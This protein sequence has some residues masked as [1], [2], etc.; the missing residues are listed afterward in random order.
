MACILGML[1]MTILVQYSDVIVGISFAS[2]HTLA[3]PVLWTFVLLSLFSGLLY[4]VGRFRFLNRA[5]MLF[6]MYAMLI[7]APLTTQGFWHRFVA[8]IATNPRSGSFDRLD[9]TNDK[10]WPHGLNLM[11][12]AFRADNAALQAVGS[13]SWEEV[14][15]EEGRKAVLPVLVNREK[16]AVSGVRIRLPIEKD[17]KPVVVRGEQYLVTILARATDLG[18]S[19]NYYCRV[20]NDDSTTPSLFFQSSEGP[21]VTFQRRKGFRRVGAYGVKFSPDAKES[22]TVEFGLEGNG[23]LELWDPKLFSVAVIETLFTGKKVVTESEYAQLAPAERA[24]LIVKPDR[25]WSLAGLKY[26]LSG[27]IPVAEWAVPVLVWTTFVLLLLTATLAVN[28]ILRNQWIDNE[29]YQMPVSRIPAA[30]MDDEGAEYDA[31]PPIWKNKLMYAGF[32]ICLVWMLLKAWSFYNPKVPDLT[33]KIRFGQLLSD[34]GW[35]G[36]WDRWQL[37][38]DGIFLPMCIFMELNV[39]MSLVIGYALFRMQSWF[40][41]MGGYTVDPLFPYAGEQAIGAYLGYAAIVLFFTR[42]YLWKTLKAAIRGDRAASAGEA[43]SY[44]SAFVL[45]ALTLI[46]SVVW[47]RWLG[48]STAGILV[49]FLFL[50]T[51]GFVASK[52][53]A[54]CGTPW[55]YFAPG[56]LAL[57]L[58]LLGG[59]WRFGPE[60]MIFCFMASFMIAQTVFFLI[61]GAQMEL[62]GLGKRWNVTPRHLAWCAVIGVLGGMLIGG[63]VF[64]S[65][66]YALGGNSLQY[67]WAFDVKTWYFHAYNQDML[68]AGNAYLGQAKGATD[69]G[70]APAWWA[71]GLSASITAILAVFRQLFSGFWFHPVGFVLGSSNFMDYIWGSALT[72]WVIRS[73]VVRLGGAATVRNKLQPFFVGVFLGACAAYLLLLAHAAYLQSMG[74]E[75]IC[76]TLTPP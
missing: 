64:L 45:L 57:F 75:R 28:V 11:R 65:N 33:V 52:I 19:A 61:P 76:P 55:G 22:V 2:E 16:D 47:A 21:K 53:R 67:A 34:P 46:G 13:C 26:W 1:A 50:L 54:E 14:E 48:I 8:I 58:G 40:G 49:F 60:A 71:F 25:M 5:E 27:Y 29:R 73:V 72:A 56:N 44:R 30:L 37:E 42:R 51:I 59:V 20:F 7:A 38:I 36:M 10:L 70:L 66:A 69:T 39:L 74:I 63:W 62:L 18:P 3:L 68:A 24:N 23:R 32:A 12:N 4:V 31:M 35:G 41:Y 43:M 15:Y 17:G 9:A 6:V